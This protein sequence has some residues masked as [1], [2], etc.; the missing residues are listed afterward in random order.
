MRTV[1]AFCAL[2]LAT[3]ALAQAP[4][5]L[6]PF[7]DCG[8]LVLRDGALVDSPDSRLKPRDSGPL[9]TPPADAKAAYCAREKFTM[10]DGDSRLIQ[11]RLPMIIRVGGTEGILE[12]MPDVPFNY[13][14]DGN[15]Y[16]PGRVTEGQETIRA[17]QP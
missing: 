4:A 16:L 14:K 10:E 3:P 15:R 7:D 13:H 9:A 5:Q 12:L 8:W 11:M 2:L 6:V 17:G 1:L